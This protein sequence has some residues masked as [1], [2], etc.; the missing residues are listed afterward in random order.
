MCILYTI[1]LMCK[2]YTKINVLNV[3]EGTYPFTNKFSIHLLK[4]LVLFILTY[5]VLIAK[6]FSNG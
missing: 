2:M 3:H 1:F 4:K 5:L 6:E